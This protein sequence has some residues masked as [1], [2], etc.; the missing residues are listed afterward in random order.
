MPG[1]AR[2]RPISG[3][4]RYRHPIEIRYVDTDALGHVNNAVYFS[5]FEAA[6]AGYY[7]QIS[8]HPFGTGPGADKR[9]FVIAEAHIT[10]RQPALFGE[11]LSCACRVSWLGRSSFGL[12]YR[13]EVE[14]SSIGEARVVAD[15]STVQ[16]FYDLEAG[17]VMRM[18]TELLER[19]AEYEGRE[20]PTRAVEA[21]SQ[22]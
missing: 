21:R 3:A 8:G 5:Y 13:V 22:G 18:P 19:F 14:G 17:S 2:S 6:R 1:V 20:L 10:Y 12:D 4:F 15:G 16:V 7:E 11:P 9:T